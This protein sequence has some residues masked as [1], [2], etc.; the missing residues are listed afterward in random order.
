MSF[1]QPQ[2]PFAS[3]ASFSS[4]G[5]NAAEVARG[6]LMPVGITIMAVSILS[7]LACTAYFILNTIVLFADGGKLLEPPPELNESERMG[8][9]I[10]AYGVNVL[11]VVVILSQ[12][13]IALGSSAFLR[14]KGRGLAM[15]TAILNLIP[16]CSSPFCVIGIPLGIW[17]LIVLNDPAVRQTMR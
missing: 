11:F 6:K 16:C 15:F 8:F 3:P 4:V 12:L 13:V 7:F 10:G 14:G 17:A 1:G 9:Y 2:N 5:P